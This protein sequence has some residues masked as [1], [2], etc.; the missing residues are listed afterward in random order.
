MGVD[1][2]L[3]KC[4][5]HYLC[6]KHDSPSLSP[7]PEKFTLPWG[8][9]YLPLKLDCANRRGSMFKYVF[10]AILGRYT[11]QILFSQ[12]YDDKQGYRQE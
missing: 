7:S 1:N 3:I 10:C 5:S 8:L 12:I 9:Y 2:Y 11:T 6:P 4:C